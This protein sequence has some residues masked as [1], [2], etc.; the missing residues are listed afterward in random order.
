MSLFERTDGCSDGGEA[1]F[2]RCLRSLVSA[3]QNV[4]NCVKELSDQRDELILQ[5][6]AG[7]ADRQDLILVSFVPQTE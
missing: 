7:T 6:Q 3:C 1:G 5:V 2:F 4:L